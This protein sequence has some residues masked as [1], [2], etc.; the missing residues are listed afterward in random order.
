M[1]YPRTER[2][3]PSGREEVA[4]RYTSQGEEARHDASWA[5]SYVGKGEA[6]L[7]LDVWNLGGWGQSPFLHFCS[8][9]LLRHLC[10]SS[11]SLRCLS[12]PGV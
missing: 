11:Q 4:S 8:S 7:A 1:L 12:L 3:E 2:E 9:A 10:W 5:L 6:V